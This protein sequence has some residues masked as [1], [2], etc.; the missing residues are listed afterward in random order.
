MRLGRFLLLDGAGALLW[1]TA[2]VVAGYLLG[3]QLAI[4]LALLQGVSGSVA[5][6]ALLL[7]VAYLAWKLIDR[8]RLLRELRIAR[9]TPQELK[10]RLE[11]GEPLLV[12][13]L[14]HEIEL[15]ADRQTL[16]GALRIAFEEL[17]LRHGEIPRDREIALFCS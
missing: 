1:A 10:R 5:S 16:P 11:A 2:Y 14:R 3:P 15:D 17:D 6:G 12:V 4:A 7:V 13:D 8:W 9:I